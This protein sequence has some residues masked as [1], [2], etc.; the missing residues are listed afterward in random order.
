VLLAA[1]PL[2]PFLSRAAPAW[3]PT[4]FYPR[5]NAAEPMGR[6]TS[7][8]PAAATFRFRWPTATKGTSVRAQTIS[9]TSVRKSPHVFGG[10]VR[11]ASYGRR[12]LCVRS[13]RRHGVLP[14]YV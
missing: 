13:R 12:W 3:A 10:R 7:G 9:S 11:A 5:R 1:A 6:A 14:R 8:Q 4:G 2:L